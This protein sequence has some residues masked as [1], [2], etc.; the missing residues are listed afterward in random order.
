MDKLR[1]A[2][3]DNHILQGSRSLRDYERAKRIAQDITESPN[4][5]ERAIK[6][7]ADYLKI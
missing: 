4:E 3:E 5:Y 1:K 2:L 6:Y 7:I